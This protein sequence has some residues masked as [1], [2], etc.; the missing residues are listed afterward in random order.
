MYP[1]V[2]NVTFLRSCCSRHHDAVVAVREYRHIKREFRTIGI[3]GCDLDLGI[4]TCEKRVVSEKG[5]TQVIL[6]EEADNRQ[7]DIAYRVNARNLLFHLGRRIHWGA[8][9]GRGKC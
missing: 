2:L 7:T 3:A 4:Q 6:E 9:L 1:V 5:L 8:G